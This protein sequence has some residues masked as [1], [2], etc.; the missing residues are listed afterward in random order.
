MYPVGAVIALIVSITS[1]LLSKHVS[2][3]GVIICILVF[4]PHLTVNPMKAK[5][6]LCDPVWLAS[7]WLRA[8]LGS[9][10]ICCRKEGGMLCHFLLEGRLLARAAVPVLQM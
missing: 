3:P 1:F 10:N 8:G 7:T 9:G 2:L 6:Q 5:H 4:L